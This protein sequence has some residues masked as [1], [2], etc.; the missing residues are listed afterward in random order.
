MTRNHYKLIAMAIAL[1]FGLLTSF[2]W[3]SMA[4]GS[5]GILSWVLILTGPIL[6]PA[7]VAVIFE[8]FFPAR[9]TD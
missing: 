8:R 7:L 3:Y 2:N 4:D 1:A 9:K 6:Y 5:P